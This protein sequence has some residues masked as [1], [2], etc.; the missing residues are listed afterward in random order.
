M[1][2]IVLAFSGGLDTSWCVAHLR[3]EL[4][5]EVVTV[6]VDTGGFDAGALEA[7]QERSRALGAVAHRTVDGRATVWERFVT[8]LI[9]GNVLRGGVYPLSVAAERIVQAEEVARVAKE[10]G[11]THLAHGATAAGNDGVRFDVAFAVQAPGLKVLAPIREGSVTREAAA[12]YLRAHGVP[13][14]EAQATY[15]VNRGL[16]GTTIGGGSTHD[17]W[18]EVPASLLGAMTPEDTRDAYHELTLGFRGGIPRR[19][20]GRDLD[21]VRMADDLNYL[22]HAYG[23]GRGIHVGDTILGLK[24]RI[25]FD[26]PAPLIL[27]QAHRELEKLVHSRWQQFW[28]RTLGEFYGNML[29]EA[30]YYDPVM[31]DV[32]AWLESAQRAVT[33][34]VR[35][36]LSQGVVQVTGCRSP[37]SLVDEDM[38]RYGELASWWDGR[39]YAGFA[40]IYALGSVLAAR[41]DDRAPIAPARPPADSHEDTRR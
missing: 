41:R 32:E 17:T 14:S 3:E 21:G 22:G 1:K 13:V 34:E 25:A 30:L 4:G 20:G 28:S 36:R 33:G 18:A 5:A 8:Y 23:V 24:G 7:I 16:W 38:G 31:R 6:T 29:H 11:A 10:V 39:D 27:V 12:A 2:K 26:A 15:S 40:R 37:Y 35:V 19:L 9:R